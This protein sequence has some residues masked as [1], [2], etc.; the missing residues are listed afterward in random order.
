M[1][2]TLPVCLI[3]ITFVYLFDSSSAC[4]IDSTSACLSDW[5]IVP[6]PV[7]LIDR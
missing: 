4:L 5:Q 7:C 6:L 2:V 1:T 3:N